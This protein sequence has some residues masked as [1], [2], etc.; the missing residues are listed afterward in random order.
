MI[1]TTLTALAAFSLAAC[2]QA[3][4]Q[5]GE[6]DGQVGTP[7]IGAGGRQVTLSEAEQ[8]QLEQLIAQYLD[9][10]AQ[11]RAAGFT[12][13]AGINDAVAPL[14]P[15]AHHDYTV[16][17]RA[18]V[19]YRIVG[20]CDNECNDLDLEVRDS[21]GT[22]VASDTAPTDFP[23]V[24]LRPAADAAYSVRIILKTCTVAPCYVGARVLQQ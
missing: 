24:N 17:L 13:S 7:S 2:G 14:Q 6:D 5:P 21:A 19:S 22:V 23:F 8:R 15:R 11:H 1:R 18:G 10:G 9:Y 20:A 4:Q 3:I 12:R 16:N